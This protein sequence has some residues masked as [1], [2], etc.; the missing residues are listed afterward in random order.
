MKTKKSDEAESEMAI[1][2]DKDPVLRLVPR[3]FPDLLAFLA[4]LVIV[5]QALRSGDVDEKSMSWVNSVLAGELFTFF[6]VVALVEVASR[7]RTPP[8][9]WV[10][11]LTVAT[12]LVF[13]PTVLM[14]AKWSWHGGVWMFLAFL[15]SMVERFRQLW[16]LPRASRLEK[17]RT[18]ALAFDRFQTGLSGYFVMFFILLGS[19]ML[20]DD[21]DF[22]YHAAEMVIPIFLALFFAITCIDEIRV[23][24]E[25]FVRSPR[26]LWA[27]PG[28]PDPTLTEMKPI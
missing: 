4:S 16:T 2:A 19:L 23:H 26:R 6:F 13:F 14:L 12:L 11:L 17:L 18:R 20:S 27:K 5:W 1:V 8:T 21:P 7:R 9:L 3:F 22:P 25:G 24:G 15:W 10:G 28:R